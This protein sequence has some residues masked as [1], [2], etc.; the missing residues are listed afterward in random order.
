MEWEVLRDELC[1]LAMLSPRVPWSAG[2]E[3]KR[4]SRGQGTYKGGDKQR[5]NLVRKRLGKR[6]RPHPKA[7]RDEDAVGNK[8]DDVEE[9]ERDAY[10]LYPGGFVG[11]CCC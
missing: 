5:L 11:D 2:S 9:G 6:P 10:A 7:R 4:P 8:D 1:R 3:G